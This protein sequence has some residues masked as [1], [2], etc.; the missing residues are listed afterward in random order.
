MWQLGLLSRIIPAYGAL[1]KEFAE[2]GNLHEAIADDA[3]D[4]HNDML[5][6]GFALGKSRGEW[7][8]GLNDE[9]VMRLLDALE[10]RLPKR[11]ITL[12]FNKPFAAAYATAQGRDKYPL[13]TSLAASIDEQQLGG[14]ERCFE[15]P[16]QSDAERLQYLEIMGHRV[17]LFRKDENKSQEKRDKFL[18]RVKEAATHLLNVYLSDRSGQEAEEFSLSEH[19]SKEMK[20]LANKAYTILQRHWICQCNLR[21]S[22]SARAREARL[23]LVRHRQLAPR[24]SQ[25]QIAIEDH[26]TAKF[27]VLLPMCRDAV[28]WQ[29][30]NIEVL[31][32]WSQEGARKNGRQVKKDICRCLSAIK[33]L[34]ADF[35]AD[36]T[37]LWHITP[38]VRD[39]VSSHTTMESL[40][41]LLG[42]D[43]ITIS[44]VSKCTPE[45]KLMLCYVLANSLLFFYPG[46]WFRAS[47][48]SND[49]YFIRRV[50]SATP[51][52]T[53][54]YVSVNV[55]EQP[56][57]PRNYC[58]YHPH[59]VILDLGIIFL[60]IATGTRF[61][62]RTHENELYKQRNSDGAQAIQ[63]LNDLEAR[64]SID[65]SKRMSTALK[66]VIRSCL[67][68]EPPPNFPSKG[69]SQEGPI[70][71]YILSCIVGPIA[72]ELSHGHKISLDKLH[73]AI[74]EDI[75]LESLKQLGERPPEAIA[76]RSSNATDA[77]PNQVPPFHLNRRDI[78][79]DSDIDGVQTRN[80]IREACLLGDG[81]DKEIPVD[82]N[83]RSMAEEWFDWHQGA[84]DRIADMYE[85]RNTKT[86]RPEGVKIA[87]LDSGIKLSKLG[88]KTYDY[89]PKMAFHDFVDGGTEWK[90]EV[91]HGTHLAILLRRMAPTAI[92]HVGRVFK[93]SPTIKK[94]AAQIDQVGPKLSSALLNRMV[95]GDLETHLTCF[96]AIRHAVDKWEVDIIV[97][98]FG[99]SS[100]IELV[101]GAI[102]HAHAHDV[103]MFA[104]ASNDGKNRPDGVAW[105]ARESGVICVH[106]GDG[107]GNASSF[108]PGPQENMK[109]M[110]LGECIRSAWP[111][112]PKAADEHRHMSGTSCSAPIAA[113]IAAVVLDY[114]RSFLPEDDWRKLRRVDPIRRMFKRLRDPESDGHYW[115][116]KHWALFDEKR[117]ESWIQG[118][119]KGRGEATTM[120]RL[121]Y[122][123]APNFSINPSSDIAPRLGSIF[124]DLETLTGPLNQHD[125]L[126]I[127]SNLINNS[128]DLGFN[129][130]RGQGLEGA[131][132]LT[133][134]VAQGIGGSGSF[135]YSFARDR[136]V[137]YNC[138]RLETLEF[139]PDDAF[140][141]ECILA[142]QNVQSFLANSFVGRKRVYMV[143]GLK[144]ATGFSRTVTAEK[145][146]GPSLRIM[147]DFTP[148][149][150]PVQAGPE[151]G[152]EFANSR[153]IGHEKTLNKIVFA[154]QVICIKQ[155]RDGRVKSRRKAGGKYSTDKD[156]SD[157]DDD[158]DEEDGKEQT[159]GR[160]TKSDWEL[161][162]LYDRNIQDEL[163]GAVVIDVG[164]ELAT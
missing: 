71:H 81:G 76:R 151:V 28:E 84:L 68:P 58:Q 86:Q 153:I 143:T 132:G 32:P 49:V 26:L 154:Y 24:L 96:K 59:P 9:V 107:H 113:G 39:G 123:E 92:I 5:S 82:E 38:K 100:E 73:N 74:F 87:I 34:Q 31:K 103:L 61:I 131:M 52:F 128:A 138:E 70:R 91:G 162:L 97:M 45:Q 7:A 22:R 41:Q 13:L 164:Q 116:V 159:G 57:S 118:E 3:N 126:S 44:D 127:P 12:Q 105:P 140:A 67:N 60:E 56:D 115:R 148:M 80:R 108:T 27:E 65:R 17:S 77:T 149:G 124:S 95:G 144:I 83:K 106:A 134:E 36:K 78:E 18:T 147:A 145:S 42:R 48:S 4:C 37:D 35:V 157:D 160:R 54:P 46:S 75:G 40:Q 155:K 139:K 98:S 142:S 89:H 50:G 150:A 55:N 66:Q 72:L 79:P 11:W 122:F 93:K 101:R 141:S 104:A 110:V 146:H 112:G 62:R 109:I 120:G 121:Y 158:D 14:Y 23:S 43:G 64:S 19:P 69:L 135:I 8:F 10:G 99:F 119:I 29:V 53:F 25:H 90:D 117:D 63:Q 111:Q 136:N 137:V 16:G 47:W 94:S 20:E 102:K 21:T 152:L 51:A 125:H 156:D 129:E 30:T 163:P 88:M 2:N 85:L 133:A 1:S 33:G 6:I 15:L 114:A 161:E 130:M